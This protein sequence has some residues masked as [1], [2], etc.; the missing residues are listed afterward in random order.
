MKNPRKVKARLSYRG[1]EVQTLVKQN[2]GK[3]PRYC[4]IKVIRKGNSIVKAKSCLFLFSPMETAFKV[5]HKIKQRSRFLFLFHR[6]RNGIIE[7]VNDIKIQR[8]N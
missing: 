3:N 7:A 1:V 6:L 2:T 5:F 8:G 4:L